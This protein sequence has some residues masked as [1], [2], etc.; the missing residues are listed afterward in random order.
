MYSRSLFSRH[1]RRPL[2]Q[3]IRYLSSIPQSKPAAAPNPLGQEQSWLTQRVKANPVLHAVF[4]GFA[5]ALGYSSP[6]QLANRRALHLYNAL[7]VTRADQESDFWRNGISLFLVHDLLD[8]PLHIQIVRSP[9]L[10]NLGS[11]SPT[12]TYGFSP[13][14]YALSLHHMEQTTYKG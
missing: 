13:S 5:R 7:C 9:R 11:P 3:R 6:K 4:L 1:L 14:V 12:C 8:K 2:H 10:S